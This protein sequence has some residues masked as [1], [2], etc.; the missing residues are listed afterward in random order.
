MAKGLPLFLSCP[1]SLAPHV[2]LSPCTCLC[3]LCTVC[4]LLRP[5]RR[6]LTSPSP[7]GGVARHALFANN[8]EYV[9]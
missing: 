6:T 3:P 9:S 7:A 8:G 1:C 5:E 4:V 2:S